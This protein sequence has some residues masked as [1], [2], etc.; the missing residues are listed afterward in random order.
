MDKEGDTSEEYGVEGIPVLVVIG[1]DGKI[2]S[3]YIGNQTE[4]SLRTATIEA[5]LLG[6]AN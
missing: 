4:Q 3:Y 2:R 5:A 1:R 6:S